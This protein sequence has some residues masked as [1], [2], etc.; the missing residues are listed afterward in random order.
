MKVLSA[1][2]HV[3]LPVKD[4]GVRV[5]VQTPALSLTSCG[6]C[7]GYLLSICLG[8]LCAALLCGGMPGT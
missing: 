4:A 3:S 8:P 5:K 6:P 7:I 1:E 2:T